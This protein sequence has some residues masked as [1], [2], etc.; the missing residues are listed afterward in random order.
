MVHLLAK[1]N[2]NVLLKTH[3]NLPIYIYIILFGPSSASDLVMRPFDLISF[4]IVSL[5]VAQVIFSLTYDLLE[6]SILDLAAVT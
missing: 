6:L 1:Q 3:R 4:R 2:N 5:F